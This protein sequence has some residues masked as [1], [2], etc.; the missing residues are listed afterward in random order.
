MSGHHR[1]LLFVTTIT[2][3][4]AVLSLTSTACN[5]KN[6]AMTGTD[7]EMRNMDCAKAHYGTHMTAMA[8]NAMLQDMSVADFHFVPHTSELSGTG[9]DRLDRMAVLLNTYGGTVRYETDLRDQEL[10]KRRMDHVREY[11]ALAGCN[12]DRVD[13][14]TMISGGR[15]MAADKA[16]IVDRKGTAKPGS[17]GGAPAAASGGS[18]GSQN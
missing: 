3:T 17:T 13:V 1:S 6:K 4:T 10:L 5:G 16:I 2:A 7:I 8:D 15:G 9:A 14:K 11:L 12:M 18:S